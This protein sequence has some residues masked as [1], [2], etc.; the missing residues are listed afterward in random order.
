[1]RQ[2]AHALIFDIHD[3]VVPLPGS[4]PVRRQ[5]VERALEYLERLRA[6]ANGDPGLQLEL[7]QAY[8]QIGEVLGA[9][10]QPNLGDRQGAVTRLRQARDLARTL[11]TQPDATPA[12]L[13]ELVRDD[14]ALSTLLGVMGTHADARALAR[15]AQDTAERLVA[16]EPRDP[17][18]RELLAIA[19]FQVALQLQGTPEAPAAWPG[20]IAAFEDLLA[21]RP[22]DPKRLRNVALAEKYL[23]TWYDGN[24]RRPDALPHFRR[25]MELDA[26]RV[27]LRPDDRQAQ[28]DLAIDQANV[29]GVLHSTDR[30][31]S[32]AMYER[33]VATRR[34]LAETDP[35]DVFAA[36]RLGAGLWRLGNAY[37]LA[38][39][40]QDAVMTSEEATR[41]LERAVADRPDVAMMSDLAISEFHLG[42]IYDTLHRSAAACGVWRRVEQRLPRMDSEVQ[43]SDL[44]RL[45]AELPGRLAACSQASR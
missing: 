37:Y 2:L 31:A 40:L 11:A 9:P 28:I 25:A 43:I 1:V 30:P 22:D 5:I 33:S 44:P 24:R 17:R 16:R 8:R 38:G 12:S 3:A 10:G 15:E 41:V 42:E 6:D 39:R 21:Q 34:H 29:A 35:R 19:R 13:T 27:S 4:T 36:G 23:G 26:R 20:V 45:R 32:I 7:S 14:T 18:H